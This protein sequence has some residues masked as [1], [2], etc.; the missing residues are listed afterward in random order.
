M[1]EWA[2]EAVNQAKTPLLLNYEPQFMLHFDTL[3]ANYDLD[4]KVQTE[5]IF[6]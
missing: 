1:A 4:E 3:A 6:R 5:M 2:G